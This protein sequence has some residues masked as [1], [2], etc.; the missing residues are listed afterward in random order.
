MDRD[1]DEGQGRSSKASEL[2]GRQQRLRG[3]RR[4]Q[5]QK[6]VGLPGNLTVEAGQIAG[7]QE[8]KE[9]QG[10][11]QE[12]S[13]PRAEVGQVRPPGTSKQDQVRGRLS[14]HRLISREKILKKN[15]YWADCRWWTAVSTCEWSL[16]MRWAWLTCW[17]E[18]G[19][20]KSTETHKSELRRPSCDNW[21]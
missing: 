20:W 19:P 18:V 16:L 17:M 5:R 10:R 15:I 4:G 9:E 11:N 1:L 8:V 14:P 6:Q 2:A 7:E 13:R 21:P 12:G 3:W